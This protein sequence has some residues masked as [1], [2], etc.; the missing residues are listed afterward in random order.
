M[1]PGYQNNPS[2]NYQQPQ[3]NNQSQPTHS[4]E[5]G[6]QCKQ[7][8]RDP[9]MPEDHIKGILTSLTPSTFQNNILRWRSR[10]CYNRENESP[11]RN[12]WSCRDCPSTQS[13]SLTIQINYPKFNAFIKLYTRQE[14]VEARE[15]L[16][17]ATIESA[18]LRVG[19]GCGTP[20]I[21]YVLTNRIRT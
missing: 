3:M 6:L 16:Q 10:R 5:T 18:T 17:N 2:S 11:I 15:K 7:A 4:F 9:A 14:A 13:I 20:T 21:Y 8:Y 12:C 1:N 19:W